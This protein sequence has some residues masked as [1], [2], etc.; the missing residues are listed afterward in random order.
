MPRNTVGPVWHRYVLPCF[1]V[2]GLTDENFSSPNYLFMLKLTRK[3]SISQSLTAMKGKYPVQLS[4]K[5]QVN[6]PQV[7]HPNSNGDEVLFVSKNW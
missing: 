7:S 1:D 5:G 3:F 6:N 2:Y 4:L